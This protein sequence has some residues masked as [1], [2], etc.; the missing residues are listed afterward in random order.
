MRKYNS[1]PNKTSFKNGHI[2]WNKGKKYPR[3]VGNKHAFKGDD[4]CKSQFHYEARSVLK[5]VR[6]CV[7][8]RKFKPRKMIVH[9][10]D[11]NIKNNHISNLQRMCRSCHIK[12]H[13]EKIF[14]AKIGCSGLK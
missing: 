12:H 9:H 11:E 6:K 2:P 4:R 10:I 7:V 14:E 8:C 3:M 1:K 5:H 13:R